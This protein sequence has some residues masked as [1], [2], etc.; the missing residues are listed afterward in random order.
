[1]ITCRPKENMSR[2][3]K[4]GSIGMKIKEVERVGIRTSQTPWRIYARWVPE[5]TPYETH[6]GKRYFFIY[7]RLF[8]IWHSFPLELQGK[9]GRRLVSVSS[10]HPSPCWALS[11]TPV[12]PCET[13]MRPV[14]PVTPNGTPLQK[15]AK[16]PPF[17]NLLLW[18][19]DQPPA[20]GNPKQQSHHRVGP[21]FIFTKRVPETS[22]EM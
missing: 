2:Y 4:E 17:Q 12:V 14:T 1:M 16:S 9:S 22:E 8:S 5:A 20:R 6:G 7:F 21:F 15:P 13:T 3:Q 19:R 18:N 11:A 10:P